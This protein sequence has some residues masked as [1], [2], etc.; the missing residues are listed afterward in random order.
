MG[1]PGPSSMD[2]GSTTDTSELSTVNPALP[3][4]KLDASSEEYEW[5][6]SNLFASVP[7]PFLN[8]PPSSLKE[9]SVLSDTSSESGVADKREPPSSLK[10]RSGLS[11]TTTSI[12]V[13]EKGNVEKQD[14][15]RKEEVW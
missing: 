11:D 2:A 10:E 7:Y 3:V 9:R 1:S 4:E 13:A 5:N 8:E 14:L 6:D 12:E 15:K